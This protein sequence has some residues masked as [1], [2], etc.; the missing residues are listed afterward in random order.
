[1]FERKVSRNYESDADSFLKKF[2]ENRSELPLST[3]KEIEKHDR[4]FQIRDGKSSES[5]E[6]TIWKDF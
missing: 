2:E 6:P 1:M 4:I 5:A 3:K